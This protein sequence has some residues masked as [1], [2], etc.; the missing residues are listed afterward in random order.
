V[1]ARGFWLA[2]LGALFGAAAGLRVALYSGGAL[3]RGRLA[4]PV[5]S[6]GN[7]SV[8][9]TGKTPL[10]AR[11]A[12]LLRDEG[13]PVA[14]LSRGYGGRRRSATLLVS[15]GAAVLADPEQAGDEAVMLAERLPGVVVAVGR[16][17]DRVGRFVES[18]FGP[19]VH[20]LDDGFQHL[21]LAR[22]LD[23]VCVDAADLRDRPLPAGRLR[24]PVSALRRA[25]VVLIGGADVETLRP[26]L[27]EQPRF[28]FRRRVA[29]FRGTGGEPA[30]APARA[31]LLSGIARP[32]RFAEDARAA[33]VTVTGHD[34]YRDH[35]R[36]GAA[37]LEA[38][39]E[40]AR[41]AGS[42]ALLTTAKDRVR[43]RALPASL[44]LLVME[45]APVI[46]GERELLERLRVAAG[47]PA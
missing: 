34:A 12:E 45:I 29:G 30:D 6:V 18:H 13:L 25:D 27:G 3:P 36:F 8:G 24:E 40:R 38:A 16:R 9:G 1:S 15:D 32:E 46:E 44:P 33:G 47:R 2:P 26:L 10:V 41:R 42:D 14:I 28:A 19:R 37:E 5:I 43:I 23:L 4:G 17:R 11:L 20:L 21:R 31:Y 39:A 35:H 22:D 7:L